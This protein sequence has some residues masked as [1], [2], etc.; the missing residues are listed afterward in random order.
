[1]SNPLKVREEFVSL[2]EQLK[3]YGL[4]YSKIAKRIGVTGAIINHARAGNAAA[5]TTAH[6]KKLKAILAEYE[7]DDAAALKAVQKYAKLSKGDSDDDMTNEEMRK[8][9]TRI[10]L[11]NAQMRAIL[12]EVYRDYQLRK[13]E[14]GKKKETN[15]H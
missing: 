10:E 8:K 13:K 3:N 11:E 7:A 1:M 15:N 5:I 2:V 6:I 14:A 12:E 9:I 4:S